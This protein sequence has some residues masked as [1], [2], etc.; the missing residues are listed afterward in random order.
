MTFIIREA[1]ID[2]APSLSAVL[3]EIIACTGQMR[4]HDID[5]VT[6][7]YIKNPS[8]I[9]C[10]VAIDNDE[11]ILG[12]QSLIHAVPGNRFNV[13]VGYG[14][15]GTHISPKAHRKGVGKALFEESLEAAKVAKIKMIDAYI[16]ADNLSAL[17]YYEALG[18][19]TYR[20]PHG[21]IQK[22]YSL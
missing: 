15:I 14:I 3:N 17:H 6:T 9:L 1:H 4:P 5:F 19:K 8:S 12:F 21:I 10:S 16:A 2:D 22:M 13:P 20:T 11:D 18:F 7:N